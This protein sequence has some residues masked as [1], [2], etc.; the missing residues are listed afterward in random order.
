MCVSNRIE[1]FARLSDLA[2]DFYLD[3][4]V[5]R[6]IEDSQTVITLSIVLHF[7]PPPPLSALEQSPSELGLCV[8]GERERLGNS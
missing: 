1:V 5:N 2:L 3:Q 7:R 4:C 8:R 6:T